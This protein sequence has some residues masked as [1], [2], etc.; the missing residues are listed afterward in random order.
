MKSMIQTFKLI[1]FILCFLLSF[2]LISQNHQQIEKIKGSW[3]GKLKVQGIE[4][5]LVIN[6]SSNEKDSI[7]ATFDSPD[8]GAFGIPTSKIILTDDS[9]IVKIKSIGG[10]FKGGFGSGLTELKGSWSQGGVAFPIDLQ[11]QEKPAET[12]H[13]PQEPKPP[14]SYSQKEVVFKNY[15][16]DGIEL[17]GT[18]TM[19]NEGGPF[20]VV[21]LITGSGPKTGT[22]SCWAINRFSYLPIT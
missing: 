21:V 19:P 15:S 6:I 5:K 10:V 9:L 1:T 2:P 13:R 18:L 22:K 17:A 7:I 8:Q 14:F 12:I 20:P 3:V 11:H 16:A 4:L